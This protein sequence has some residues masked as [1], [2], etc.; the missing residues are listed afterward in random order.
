[1]N[2]AVLASQCQP[3]PYTRVSKQQ[4]HKQTTKQGLKKCL[5]SQEIFNSLFCRNTEAR[6]CE[7][8]I[9]IY[10]ISSVPAKL[11]DRWLPSTDFLSAPSPQTWVANVLS[12]NEQGAGRN[13]TLSTGHSF[14]PVGRKEDNVAPVLSPR[15]KFHGRTDGQQDRKSPDSWHYEPILLVLACMPWLLRQTFT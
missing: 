7:N 3:P 6:T 10:F 2:A 15:Q 14:S 8:M 12:S 1:M 5:H 11:E 9:N 13:D 4:R